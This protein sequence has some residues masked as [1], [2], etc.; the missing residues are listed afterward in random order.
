MEGL[1]ASADDVMMFEKRMLDMRSMWDSFYKELDRMFEEHQGTKFKDQN[2]AGIAW[3]EMLKK[4]DA[5]YK[6]SL[7]DELSLQ[8][9]LDDLFA[10]AFDNQFKGG[11]ADALA[12]RKSV[13]DSRNAMTSAMIYFRS[14]EAAGVPE[15][16]RAGVQAIT[17]G[18][19]A[20]LMRP[21]ERHAAW[22]RFITEV[23]QPLIGEQTMAAGKAMREMYGVKP[24]I[25]PATGAVKAVKRVDV[26]NNLRKMANEYGV[27]SADPTGKPM[28]KHVVAAY[29]KYRAEGAPEAKRITDIL[30]DDFKTALER[31]KAAKES[32]EEVKTRKSKGTP[33]PESVRAEVEA[34]KAAL[35]TSVFSKRTDEMNIDELR[36]AI[37]HDEMTGIKNRRAYNEDTSKPFKLVLDVE[38]LKFM[39]DTY[40][41]GVGD[42][43]IQAAARSIKE[44]AGEDNVYRGSSRGDE[45]IAQFDTREQADATAKAIQEIIDQQRVKAGDKEFQGLGAN[46]GIGETLESADMAMNR[47]KEIAQKAGR[48]ANRG[49]KPV[50]LR[51]TSDGLS[52]PIGTAEKFHGM[53]MAEAEAELY[54]NHISG[55]MDNAA[56]EAWSRPV[57]APVMGSELPADIQTGLRAY[58]GKVLD[59]DLPNAKMATTRNAEMRRDFALLNYQRRSG[60]D[61]AAGVVMP[62]EFW[63][64]RSI[65]NWALRGLTRPEILANYAR[66]QN[67]GGQF[68]QEQG[69]TRLRGKSTVNFPFLPDWAENGLYVDPMKVA[70]P[71]EQLAAPFQKLY[72]QENTTTRR[73]ES[74]MSDMIEAQDM[75][76]QELADAEMQMQQRSG[77]LWDKAM[78]QARDEVDQEIRNPA[79]FMFAVSGPSLPIGIAYNAITGR[80]DRISQLPLTRTIQNLTAM[81]GIGGPEG[82]NIEAPARRLL[83]LPEIDRFHDGRIDK[84][85]ADLTAEGSISPDEAIQAM[86]DKDKT[87]PAYQMAQKRV[88]ETGWIKWLGA[89]LGVDLFPE[90]EETQRQLKTMYDTARVAWENGDTDALNKFYEQNPEYIARQMAFK[91]PEDR[92]RRYL[93]SGIWEQYNDMNSVDKR[94]AGEQLG[95]LFSDGFVNKETRAY[96]N[97]KTATLAQWAQMMSANVPKKASESL[98]QTAL[99]RLPGDIAEQVKQYDSEKARMFP[100]V[101]KQYELPEEMQ[102]KQLVDEYNKW[103]NQW[104][105]AHPQAAP[106]ITSDL[107]ELKGLP[108]DVQ[109]FVYQFR[110]TRDTRFP[111]FAEQGKEFA[112]LGSTAERKQYR[113]THPEYSEYL[114]WRDQAA[115]MYPKA[116][117]YILSEATLSGKIGGYEDFN[118]NEI[119]SQFSPQL[120]RQFITYM[121]GQND[122]LSSGG[123]KELTRIWEQAGKPGDNFDKFLSQLAM[124][125]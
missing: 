25:D 19:P 120:A 66:L 87:S 72:E 11:Y 40:G 50:N 52:A 80:K 97:I 37:T 114:K 23:Y 123:Y 32:G 113:N 42:Q 39:N 112:S 85:L 10:R 14:G 86:I 100:G 3:D 94:I 61:T 90:G 16:V 17:N 81:A 79:D 44:A 117:P 96:D 20:K 102:D 35:D 57:D 119:I 7:G 121:T 58:L 101:N 38:G 107:S 2:E 41:H 67:I 70:F 24:A 124:K 18:V 34:A 62:Y 31:R 125:D 28:D 27:T 4:Q 118:R 49:E 30:E 54:L 45:F 59:N 26:D 103:R 68:Q 84:A 29:N 74:L 51:M 6:Q 115:A 99:E 83:G 33:P 111:N 88:A 73:A 53:P 48:R 92:L 109:N 5:L 93:I 77:P 21:D 60:F 91:E 64:T 55:A 12:W 8:G 106:H 47:S 105:A 122:S 65:M 22:K 76:Q 15:N 46:I 63:Y 56:R 110:A 78:I 104:M 1:N 82:V 36:F 75:T 43:V 71:F 108:Q 98:P 116:A 9:E 89:P 13:R 95:S 69:P